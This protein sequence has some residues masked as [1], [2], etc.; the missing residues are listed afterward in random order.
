MGHVKNRVELKEKE[1]LPLVEKER[2]SVK[3][4]W[5]DWPGDAIQLPATLFTGRYGKP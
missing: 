2:P 1:P 4:H 3:V 5:E